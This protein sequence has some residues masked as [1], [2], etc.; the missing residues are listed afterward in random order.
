MS[1]GAK[2]RG[3]FKVCL[4]FL[5]GLVWGFFSLKKFYKNAGLGQH[6]TGTQFLNQVKPTLKDMVVSKFLDY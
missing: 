1:S 2:I 4:L 3:K 6:P 5:Q